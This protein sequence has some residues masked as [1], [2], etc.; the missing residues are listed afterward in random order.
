MVR[1]WCYRA[2]SV[3]L[4]VTISGA[5]L[6][7]ADRETIRADWNGF[8]GQV[9]DRGLKGRSARVE[10]ASGAEVHS[11]VLDAVANGLV[12]NANRSARQWK[13]G[14]GTALIPLDQIRK[15]RFDGRLGHGGLLG[16]ALGAGAGAAVAGATVAQTDI[17]EGIGVI[18]LPIIGVA[19]TVGG[20][21]AGYFI[22]KSASRPAP[23]FVITTA[24]SRP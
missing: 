16:L 10:L 19:V 24:S 7:A 9:S 21:I 20:A 6:Q 17:T 5:N 13:T 12:V 22:G 23:E 4:T 2:L 14:D 15:V 1:A 3:V 8:R 18:L 11:K